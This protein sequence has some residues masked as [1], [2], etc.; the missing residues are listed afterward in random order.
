MANTQNSRVENCA[1]EN[2]YI[3]IYIT[4]GSNN[5]I[6]THNSVDNNAMGI[7]ILFSSDNNIIEYNTITNN[8][9]YGILFYKHFMGP[10]IKPA[11]FNN[12]IRYNNITLNY[13]GIYIPNSNDNNR[14]YHNNI[15]NNTLYQAYDNGSNYWD[16]GYPSGGNY[17]SD[18]TG[19]DNYQ[20][21]NQDIAGS[22]GIGDTPYYITGD[23]NQ[24]RYPLMNP[25]V[26]EPWT[27]TAD[28]SLKNL[29]TVN[30]EKILDLYTG[31]KLVVKFY[32]YVDAFENENVVE[33]FTTP[34]TWHVEENELA[35]H[36]EGLGVKKARLDL[37]TADTGNVL[38]TI[39]SFTVRKV[40]LEVRFMEIP[41]YWAGAS[42]K[43]KLELEIEFMEIP[44]YWAGAPS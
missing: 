28:F 25:W 4:C 12:T 2:N 5:N 1:F 40:D 43:E 20:G 38:E 27:G 26:P 29:Y 17:W 11:G 14:I 10:I 39:A 36:P 23:N 41:M 42:G 37:T 15:I 21:E 9:G 33:N 13:R 24:D 34:P 16:D 44:M 19:E 31:S 30:V 6:L 8:R 7:D 32:T 3:G 35:R 22:D 18:Y